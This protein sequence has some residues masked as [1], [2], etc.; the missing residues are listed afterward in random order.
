M[1]LCEQSQYILISKGDTRKRKLEDED[2]GLIES[3][4]EAESKKKAA[5]DHPSNRES[6]WLMK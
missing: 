4:E 5:E 2:T 3:D 6:V 1:F